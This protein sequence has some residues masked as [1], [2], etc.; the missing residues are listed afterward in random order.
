MSKFIGNMFN[1]IIP[2]YDDNINTPF[3]ARPIKA[4]RLQ[5]TNIN[6]SPS[7]SVKNIS[8][9]KIQQ[10]GGVQIIEDISGDKLNE[11][12]VKAAVS[13]STKQNMSK[14]L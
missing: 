5:R 4:H 6:N 9:N 1:N 14:Y 3:K 7:A 8:L 2:K 10:P 13:E 11:S 12:S